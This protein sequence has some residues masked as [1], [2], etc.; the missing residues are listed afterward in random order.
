MVVYKYEVILLSASMF[1]ERCTMLCFFDEKCDRQKSSGP[2]ARKGLNL[3]LPIN[4]LSAPTQRDEMTS[5]KYLQYFDFWL[6]ADWRKRSGRTFGNSNL[7][8]LEG[9]SLSLSFLALVS[10]KIMCSICDT[11][12]NGGIPK[13][14]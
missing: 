5:Q 14:T 8:G 1:S 2:V 3:A 6:L 10:F 11:A 13:R 12:D 7:V 9:F 4:Y